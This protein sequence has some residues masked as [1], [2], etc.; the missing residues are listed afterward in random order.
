MD[1]PAWM[2]LL[3]PCLELPGHVAWE[4]AAKLRSRCASPAS[5]GNDRFDR[6]A[7]HREE[8]IFVHHQEA[9]LSEWRVCV[10]RADRCMADKYSKVKAH[11][12]EIRQRVP[13]LRAFIC[14]ISD[15][16]TIL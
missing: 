11:W 6:L 16:E 3:Q 2:F 13:S 15:H 9:C 12:T 1:V 7:R 4:R 8:D 5:R 10:V 14:G